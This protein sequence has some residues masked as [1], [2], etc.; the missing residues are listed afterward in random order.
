MG[1][2]TA[3]GEGVVV[4]VRVAVVGRAGDGRHFYSKKTKSQRNRK[5]LSWMLK[6]K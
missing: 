4:V 3:A 2:G 6:K 5:N 1:E